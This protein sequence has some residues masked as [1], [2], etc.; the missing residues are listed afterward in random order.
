VGVERHQEIITGM[1]ANRLQLLAFQVDPSL[2]L[3]CP[4]ALLARS[5]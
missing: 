5:F 2:R 1:R 3:V 4:E